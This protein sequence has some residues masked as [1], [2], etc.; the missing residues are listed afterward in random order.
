MS[1]AQHDLMPVTIDIE[2]D[3]PIIC[4]ARVL[5]H[6]ALTGGDARSQGRRTADVQDKDKTVPTE[7]KRQVIDGIEQ[8]IASIPASTLPEATVQIE[9]AGKYASGLSGSTKD[10]DVH[11][12]IV[13]LHRLLRSALPVFAKASSA[14]EALSRGFDAYPQDED[15]PLRSALETTG[16]GKPANLPPPASSDDA[17][18]EKGY[19]YRSWNSDEGTTEPGVDGEDVR[20][21]PRLQ[22]LQRD[23]TIGPILN[24]LIAEGARTTQGS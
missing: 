13:R 18:R 15:R 4:L 10:Y 20:L 5:E 3:G 14:K 22:N 8:A 1:D 19:Q 12:A 2:D 7:T 17:A 11:K 16:T 23:Q 9:I 21:N 6:L 24:Q